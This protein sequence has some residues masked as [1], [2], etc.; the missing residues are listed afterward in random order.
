MV[1]VRGISSKNRAIQIISGAHN[2]VLGIFSRIIE[3]LQ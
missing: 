3:S 2:C 1:N